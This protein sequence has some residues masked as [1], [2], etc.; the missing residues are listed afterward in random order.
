MTAYVANYLKRKRIF[1][2][3]EDEL[4]HAIRHEHPPEKLAKAAEKLREARMHVFKA[5]FSKENPG[6]PPSHFEP[7]G[8]ALVWY[9]Y[10]VDSIIAT[11]SP[12]DP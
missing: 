4:L 5:K 11:Y 1:K 6:L 10:P 2:K 9:E 8:E 7:R 3:R 12:V